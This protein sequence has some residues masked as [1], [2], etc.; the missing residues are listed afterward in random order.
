MAAI[1]I[2]GTPRSVFPGRLCTLCGLWCMADSAPHTLCGLWCMADSA[3][4]TLC[5][6]WCMADSAPHTPRLALAPPLPIVQIGY[7]RRYS[8]YT[9]RASPSWCICTKPT[10]GHSI[11]Y[12]WI[13]PTH[14]CGFVSL[15]SCPELC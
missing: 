9:T 5:G 11:T 1:Q 3:P 13:T 8:V 7:T 2:K 6:L 4:H 14:L 10:G 12:I 15:G